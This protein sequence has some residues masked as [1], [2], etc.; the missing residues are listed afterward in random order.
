VTAT[1]SPA[2]SAP[3][4]VPA[5]ALRLDGVVKRY[6]GVTAL[7]GV[8]FEVEPGEVHALVGENGAGKSTL[9]GVAC[10]AVAPDE[11]RVRIGGEP[12]RRA[13]PGLARR[14]GLAVVY[15]HASVLDDLTVAENLLYPLPADLRPARRD[16]AGWVRA[17][18]DQVGA[19]G[20][21]PGAR[22][23]GLTVAQRQLVEIARALAA[24]AKVLILDEPTESLTAGETQLLF[25]Q[26]ER[27]RTAGT[28]IVYISHRFG[29]VRRVADRITVLRDG[30]S[31]GTLDA[32][33][34]TEAD[35]V[36]LIVGRRVEHVF[37]PR[38]GLRSA[39][40]RT[41]A[42][43]RVED[44]SGPGFRDV[45]F[46]VRAG[47][48]VGMAGVE[49]NGQREV[50]RAVAGLLPHTGT[51]EISAAEISTAGSDNRQIGGARQH[52]HT[53]ADAIASGAVYLPA[54]R[55]AEG[56]F[57]P[58]SVEQNI[59][60]LRHR[61]LSRL[62]LLRPR[63]ER[64]LAR[65]AIGT[66]R[67]RTP[68]PATAVQSLSGGNQQKVVVARSLAADPVLLLADE[69][70]RG[71][72][73]GSR[74]EMYRTLRDFADGGRAVLMVSADAVELA[75]LCDRVLV[76]SRGHA[77]RELT[78]ED[79]AERE[80]T[81]TAIGATKTLADSAAPAARRGLPKL[82][83]RF[84][85]FGGDRLPAAVLAVM[86]VVLAAATSAH[87]PLF[88]GPR[89]L[90]NLLLLAAIVG[91]AALGQLT[92]LL[93]GSIDLSVGP[94]IG[95]VVVVLSFFADSGRG[96]GGLMLGTA[97]ALALGA[98]VGA[99]NAGLIRLVRLPPV[100][101]TLVTYI[102]LQGVSLLLRPQPG[103]YIDGS[104]TGLL[105]RAFGAIPAALVV[106]AL[107]AVAAELYSRRTRGGIQL[108][109]VGSDE[110]RARRLGVPVGRT[111]LRA[112]IICSL[113][114]V[115]AGVVLSSVVGVGDPTLGTNYTLTAI[116][117]VVLGGA[118]VFGGRG[119][120]IGALLGAL[121]LQEITSATTFLGLPEAWQ[122]WLPGLL[123]LAGTAA[124]SRRGRNRAA[125]VS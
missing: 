63:A 3:A 89:S 38:P 71:V 11:G 18:L 50:L 84:G 97:V 24:E 118:S 99:L 6:P 111:V 41:G 19:T 16:A 21:A 40:D 2:P 56:A 30:E 23:D 80:I 112:H 67:I 92:T 34:V 20:V 88:L 8:S 52:P 77:V 120:Y 62:G 107:A 94:L 96:A 83:E 10:G 47:E 53:P 82:L 101:A 75:G 108:R 64:E 43:L 122:E 42:V 78:G 123:I 104:V 87:N 4:S 91:F 74:A 28:G 114:G 76:F 12:L 116:A 113:C 109:A 124:F 60:A 49:G 13:E 105:Q 69:P 121:L 9:M 103:G 68:D 125:P 55:H 35:V 29:E 90:F 110:I 95:L 5:P 59:S 58:L 14:L 15:Q 73:V 36:E 26:I 102:L 22:V 57:L 93:V 25:A 85:G 81:G 48:I 45:S 106:V 66:L 70:T 86:I 39:A 44:L 100:V 17:R 117:A 31:R 54:D 37:P 61:R 46:E 98:A 119:S 33:S 51:L 27:L 7:G 32:A 1:A 65:E 115:C 79:V 72:D